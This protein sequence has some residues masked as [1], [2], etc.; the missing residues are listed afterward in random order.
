MEND[1]R[2]EIAELIDKEKQTYTKLSD[3][4]WEYAE[5][6]FQEITAGLPMRTVF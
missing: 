5:P 6:R 3:A 1:F 4:I 2:K